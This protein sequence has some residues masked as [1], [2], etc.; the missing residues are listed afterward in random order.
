MIGVIM[1]TGIGDQLWPEWPITFTG[2]R[3]QGGLRASVHAHAAGEVAPRADG[4]RSIGADGRVP[5]RAVPAAPA[6]RPLSF[7]LKNSPGEV[8]GLAGAD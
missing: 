1:I 5:R 4:R 3:I 6:E 2:M 7:S 8:G